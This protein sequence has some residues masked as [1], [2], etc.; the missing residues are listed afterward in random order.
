MKY[1]K[2][3]K[4]NIWAFDDDVDVAIMRLDLIEMTEKEIN[5]MLFVSDEQIT[6]PQ[7]LSRFQAMTVL[8]LT[9]LEDGITLYQA[10]DAYINSLDNDS[11]E[12]ITAKTAWETAQEFRRDSTL[13][14]LA[15]KLFNL[16]DEQ[17]DKMFFEG[18]KI[19][20]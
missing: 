16:T 15:G 10:T 18:A 7:S 20:A 11:V 9:K 2:D 1:Y 6:V 19:K 4:N 5:T 13:I 8:K 14:Q 12:S 3:Q 17:V